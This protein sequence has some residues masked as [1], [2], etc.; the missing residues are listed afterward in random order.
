MNIVVSDKVAQTAGTVNMRIEDKSPKEAI[1]IIVEA[2]GLVM[3]QGKGDVFYIKT[4][5]EKAKEPTARGTYTFTYASAEKALPLLQA[6][7]KAA[8][9]RNS[10]SA[11]IPSSSGRTGRISTRSISSSKPSM[12]PPSRS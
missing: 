1:E 9:P 6:S 7:F 10:T 12:S 8:S 4:T 3:D 11:P 2:K 5:E